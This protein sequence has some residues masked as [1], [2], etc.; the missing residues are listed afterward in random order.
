VAGFLVSSGVYVDG[1]DDV[2]R[3]P[4]A[5]QKLPEHSAEIPWSIVPAI[6]VP[7]TYVCSE[8]GYRMATRPRFRASADEPYVAGAVLLDMPPALGWY[9]PESTARFRP[10]VWSLQSRQDDQPNIWA[11]G[12]DP[13]VASWSTPA[14]QQRFAPARR[15]I[16]DVDCLPVGQPSLAIDQYSAAWNQPQ[17]HR[18]YPAPRL[19]PEASPAA[20]PSWGLAQLP[21][22]T[23]HWAVDCPTIRRTPSPL[24]RGNTPSTELSPLPL[25][26]VAVWAP[27]F[28]GTG[29][30][31]QAR[32]TA[33]NLMARNVTVEPPAWIEFGLI[34]V[35]GPW[36]VVAGQVTQ[37]GGAWQ[38]DVVSE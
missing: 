33:P 23:I 20:E 14:Q 4:A 6:P 31:G 32:R 30:E 21:Q 35:S 34:V 38:A 26:D 9:T 15:P 7:S 2:P 19:R 11:L 28:F 27:L 10:S 8:P 25:P 12:G 37:A 5:R 24:P 18:S 22:F 36:Y 29:T 17:P 13:L 3:R 1:G 16:V